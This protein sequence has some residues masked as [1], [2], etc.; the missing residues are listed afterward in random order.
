VQVAS[1]SSTAL[2]QLLRRTVDAGEAELHC[3]RYRNERGT[4]D[5]R[6]PCGAARGR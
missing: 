4:R 5:P 3:P 6:R 2:A 1:V